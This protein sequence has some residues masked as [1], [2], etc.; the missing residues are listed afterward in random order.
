MRLSD[1]IRI[2][3]TV[4]IWD[5]NWDDLPKILDELA[6]LVVGIIQQS[7][8]FLSDPDKLAQYIMHIVIDVYYIIYVALSRSWT[9]M[10]KNFEEMIRI[11][12][13]YPPRK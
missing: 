1:A 13:G 12:L 8:G 3:R 9:N 10:L 2:L 4:E 11:Q 6:S 5:E 7:F